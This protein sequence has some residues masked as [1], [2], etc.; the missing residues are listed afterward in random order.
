MRAVPEP[1]EETIVALAR[2]RGLA[3]DAARAAELR[4]PLESLL[5]RLARI[6]AALPRA[7]EPPPSGLPGDPLP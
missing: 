2:A 4:A 5:G 6:G 1:P 3:L 7:A